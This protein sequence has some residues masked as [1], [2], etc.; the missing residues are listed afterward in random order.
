MS[1]PED[2]RAAQIRNI[3]AKTGKTLA[4]FR[5]AVAASGKAKH[6]EIRS[7]LMETYG[8]GYGDANTLTFFATADPDAVA[9]SQEAAV[10]E[11]YAGK[12][13]HLRGVHDAVL[14][15]IGSWGEFEVA[16]KKGYVSLRRKKQFAMLGPKT[17]ERAELGLNLKDNIASNRIIAQ[18]P[19]GMCQYIVA[20]SGAEAVDGEVIAALKRAFDAAG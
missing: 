11:I 16:P 6:G 2:G 4:A 12:K 8:L 9:P 7:W 17:A 20:L 5:A 13:A 15:A 14:A 1:T 18:P 10:D 3:E 19:G